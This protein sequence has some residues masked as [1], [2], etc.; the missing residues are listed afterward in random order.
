MTADQIELVRKS[1]DGLWPVRRKLA[2]LFYSRFF[3]LAPEAR[4]LFPDSMEK[5]NLKLMDALAAMV[6]ALD[7][8]EIFQSVISHSAR[9]HAQFGATPSHFVAFGEA[10]MWGFATAIWTSVH[11]GAERSLERLYDT[12]PEQDGRRGK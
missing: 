5:Q 1:F 2:E 7:R 10:L 9:Q 8:R 4:R 3:E 11:A 12:N 6:G